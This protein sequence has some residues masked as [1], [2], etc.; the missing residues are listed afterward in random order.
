MLPNAYIVGAP[1]AGTTSLSQW[2]AQHPDVFFSVPKEPF[3]WASDYP[4]LRRHY[5][6]ET[7]EAYEALFQWQR[8]SAPRFGSRDRRCT[9]TPRPPSATSSPQLSAHGLSSSCG[10][11]WTW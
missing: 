8:P 10:I 11:R 7:R 3:Y 4:G 1:K 5:G 9:C 6:F 2:L